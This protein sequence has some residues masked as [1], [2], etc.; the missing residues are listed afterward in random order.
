MEAA[1]KLAGLAAFGL[2]AA[3][4]GDWLGYRLGRSRLSLLHLRP[5]TTARIVAMVVGMCIPLATVGVAAYFSQ[6]VAL[7]LTS[8]GSLRRQIDSLQQQQTTLV[9]IRDSLQRARIRAEAQFASARD[10]LFAKQG[11]LRAAQQR[12]AQSRERLTAAQREVERVQRQAQ[13][14][15]RN[16]DEA[17]RNLDEA[18]RNL[19][20]AQKATKKAE[21]GTQKAKAALKGAEDN[22]GFA[23]EEWAGA[24]QRWT[25]AEA[26]AREAEAGTIATE[27]RLGDL[28]AQLEKLKANYEQTTERLREAPAGAVIAEVHDILL[29][30][31]VTP[32]TPRD[33][34][35]EVIR[36][37]LRADTRARELGA[38]AGPDGRYVQLVWPVP[39]GRLPPEGGFSRDD[40]LTTAATLLVRAGGETIVTAEA[41]R[42]TFAKE[43]VQIGL[44][45]RAN[46]LVFA[47]G[48]NIGVIE[49]PKG[50]PEDLA[51]GLLWR[52]IFSRQRG[53]VR[54]AAMQR[55][56]LPDPDTDEYGEVA[57]ADLLSVARE[58][59]AADGPSKVA[60]RAAGD[61]YTMGPLKVELVVQRASE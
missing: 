3:L 4:L 48:E 34:L 10:E 7:A 41:W 14:Q 26:S 33:T 16:L 42:R 2:L 8:I 11:L 15:Q 21:E 57:V 60:V 52:G 19:D 31:V 47:R 53:Q 54:A 28:Q 20:E 56:M 9:Q 38:S 23:E 37:Y 18:Q 61:T 27:A 58:V 36:V 49:F 44:F 59:A 24:D 50:T 46:Q 35:D 17:R 12:L 5:R 22:L 39:L 32:G 30:Q 51:F 25:G 45:L 1:G 13:E 55:G 43:P 29:R 40:I 6:S